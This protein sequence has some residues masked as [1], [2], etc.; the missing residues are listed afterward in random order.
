MENRA[1]RHDPDRMFPAVGSMDYL[2]RERRVDLGK[3]LSMAK[4]G[5]FGGL[6]KGRER[7]K[8]LE[9]RE[10]ARALEWALEIEDLDA[11]MRIQRLMESFEKGSAKKALDSVNA[12]NPAD[13]PWPAP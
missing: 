5:K 1:K 8:I 10:L 3:E 2:R 9:L 7:R 4:R 11:K 12:G 13:F 6:E